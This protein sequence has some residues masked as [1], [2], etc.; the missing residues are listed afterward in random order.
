MGYNEA[1]IGII[2]LKE[3]QHLKKLYDGVQRFCARHPRFGIPNLMLYIAIG[4]ILV[5][6]LQTFTAANDPFALSFLYMDAGMV[7]KGE[8]WRILT[9]V[10][11]PTSGGL[12]F[13]LISL[14][15]YYWIGS[16]LERQ[17]GTAK[18]TLYYVSG[19]LLTAIGVMVASLIT[20]VSYTI[21]GAT[22]VNL[23]LFLAFA[24]LFPNAQVL[25]FFIIPV[26]M[27]WLA[28]IDGA[29]FVFEIVSALVARN[30][31]GVVLPVVALLNFAVFIYPEV[32]YRVDRAAARHRPQAVQ[33]RKATAKA[34]EP[35]K[36][37]NHKCCVCGKT[38]AE[39]P[40]MDFRYCSRCAGYRCYCS[41]HIFSHVH[42]E[43]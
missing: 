22:Y 42:F 1:E 3:E 28:W 8:I 6:I 43:E 38:D 10:F 20:G 33:Y 25:L 37:Y 15:F 39:Y 16:T 18:F 27:K 14:Y 32:R 2:P 21:A 19:V 35:P 23:S 11:V 5:Y 7:L 12:F 30:W 26:K 4:N 9:Y 34:S 41:D 31:G 36:G 13:V 29:L 17:W 24:C 40:D